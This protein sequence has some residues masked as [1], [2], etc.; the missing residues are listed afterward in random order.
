MDTLTAEQRSER[1]SR[2]RGVDS[3]A[4]LIVRGT[5]HRLGYRFRKHS[6]GLVGRP[7]LVFASRGKIIF[8]HGCFWHRHSCAA[9]RRLPKSRI[10][11]W[12]E[13]LERNQQ[14]DAEQVRE[15]T[16]DGWKVLVIWECETKDSGLVEQRLKRFL[17]A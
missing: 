9:G 17:D 4:E 5:A 16:A 11:F 8:V 6:A 15:L 7:D 14:R 1:M 10:D 12:R 2:V 13:K 3:E